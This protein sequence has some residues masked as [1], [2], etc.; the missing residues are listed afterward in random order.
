MRHFGFAFRTRDN[1]NYMIIDMLRTKTE[2]KFQLL[3][4]L[5]FNSDRK[6]MSVLLRDN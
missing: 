5:E 1:D 3:Q 2:Q 6:R 4:V